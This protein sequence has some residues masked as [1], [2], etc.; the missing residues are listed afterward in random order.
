MRT[1]CTTRKTEIS[2]SL[3]NKL[4]GIKTLLLNKYYVDEMYGAVIIRPIIYFS[5]FL[6]K[7]FDVVIIDGLINGC[8][9]WYDDISENYP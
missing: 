9:S 8:A 4:S 6:W 1:C 5:L 7:V 3:A 2:T